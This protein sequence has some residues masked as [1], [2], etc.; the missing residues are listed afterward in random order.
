MGKKPAKSGNIRLPRGSDLP[1]DKNVNLPSQ[2]RH[3]AAVADALAT[4]QPVPPNPKPKSKAGQGFP[5]IDADVDEALQRLRSGK[6]QPSDPEFEIIRALAEEGARHIKARRTGG[7]KPRKKSEEVTRRLRAMLSSYQGLSPKL[8]GHPTGT[9]TVRA[10]RRSVVKK[11]GL[12]DDEVT[13]DMILHDLQ[14][15]R[16]L[17]RLIREGKIPNTFFF[18]K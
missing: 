13:E 12:R 15:V 10:L 11:L 14:Q 3:A 17:M 18:W 2:V 7:Q 16:P 6:L 4:G 8:Q 9:T 5:H 1:P